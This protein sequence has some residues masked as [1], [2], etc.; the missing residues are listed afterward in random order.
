MCVQFDLEVMCKR[1]P[2][3]RRPSNFHQFWSEEEVYGKKHP[4]KKKL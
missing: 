3:K 1:P 4:K 2:K